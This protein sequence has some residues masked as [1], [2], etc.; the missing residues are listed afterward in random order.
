MADNPFASR[1]IRQRS[2]CDRTFLRPRVRSR[3][4]PRCGGKQE[5]LGLFA[6]SLFW[7]LNATLN[8]L[9]AAWQGVRWYPNEFLVVFDYLGGPFAGPR[10]VPT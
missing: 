4:S 6:W 3:R 9:P 2:T 10:L 7:Q 1:A 8:R 5:C